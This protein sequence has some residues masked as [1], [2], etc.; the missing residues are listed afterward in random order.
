MKSQITLSALIASAFQARQ[1]DAPP[2]VALR[3]QR[4]EVEEVGFVTVSKR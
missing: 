4:V 3:Y 2:A 1:E